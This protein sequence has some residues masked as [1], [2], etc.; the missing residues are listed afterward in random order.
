MAALARSIAA[1][2]PLRR[3]QNEFSTIN[4]SLIRA[5]SAESQS[6]I[7]IFAHP[8][9]RALDSLAGFAAE[10]DGGLKRRLLA[11][12]AELRSLTDGEDGIL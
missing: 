4:D 6:D 10:F 1:A 8:L 7:S 9:R 2:A 5:A 3:T 11:R 12:A